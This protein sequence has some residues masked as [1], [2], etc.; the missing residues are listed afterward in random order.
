MASLDNICLAVVR[1]REQTFYRPEP[2][3]TLEWMGVGEVTRQLHASND[4]CSNLLPSQGEQVL[5]VNPPVY[6]TRLHWR[7]W[8][9]P[10]VLLKLASYCRNI[11]AN[12]QFIDMLPNR[13]RDTIRRK[14]VAEL[15][16]DGVVVKKW[17]FGLVEQAFRKQLEQLRVDNWEATTVYVQC[18]TT[19]WWEGAAEAISI[20]RQCLPH[21]RIV[22]VGA[23]ASMMS[24]HARNCAGADAALAQIPEVLLNQPHDLSLYPHS[25]GF[26]YIS[27]AGNGRS[28]GDIVDEIMEKVK[29]ARIKR[30]AFA[31]HDPVGAYGEHFRAVLTE[32]VARGLEI[33]LHALGTVA[34]S[35]L[36]G[37][38]ELVTLM[39][40]AGYVQI[41][42]SDDR[43]ISPVLDSKEHWIED[44]RKAVAHLHTVGFPTRTD[45]LSAS[46]CIGRP[47]ESLDERARVATLLAHHV[48]SVILVPYQPAPE[49]C[50]GIP[51]EDQN[52]KLFPFRKQNGQTYRDYLDLMGLAVV[53]NAKYRTRTFDFLG[54][55]MIAR[56]FQESLARRAWEPD[57]EVKG[58][59]RLPMLR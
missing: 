24:E 55:G 35:D 44:H 31:E 22:M 3:E 42:F 7:T 57:P 15:Q 45:A 9:Q 26:A 34:P 33:N 11:G 37:D 1:W 58:T 13:S 40:D 51:L 47:G 53:L 4:G 19:F 32:I 36:A 23:Y 38:P 18:F 48:G 43:N 17:R 52:G 56:L 50:P 39:R 2:I 41:V 28:A 6:D 59:L 12:A 14:R 29:I 20:I 8:L 46:L 27:L 54:D 16:L 10:T 25:P 49:E 21:T 5:F 30:F